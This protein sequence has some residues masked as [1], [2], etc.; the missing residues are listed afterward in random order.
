MR[1]A[2]MKEA[3]MND[4]ELAVF[5][6]VWLVENASALALLLL[7]VLPVLSVC[8]AGYAVHVLGKRQDKAGRK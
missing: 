5:S 7:A 2:G 6:M 8:V 3:N 4:S 1:N